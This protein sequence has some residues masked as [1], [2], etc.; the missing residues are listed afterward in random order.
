[1]NKLGFRSV[2]YTKMTVWDS[3]LWKIDIHMAKKWPELI[4]EQSFKSNIRFRSV[5][6]FI[7]VFFLDH[8]ALET[9]KFGA[10]SVLSLSSIRTENR[11]KCLTGKLAVRLSKRG[12]NDWWRSSSVAMS[13][14]L[15]GCYTQ[16]GLFRFT[17]NDTD[18]TT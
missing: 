7:E 3:G 17:F 6:R 16:W 1:M 9:F 13:R 15:Y 18:F 11:R 8:G 12:V 2:E 5:F 4:I 14:Y 10:F